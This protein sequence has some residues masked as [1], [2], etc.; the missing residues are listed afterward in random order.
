MLPPLPETIGFSY[1]SPAI[2]A[3]NNLD[4]TAS[5]DL[6]GNPRIVDVPSVPDSGNGTPPIVDMGAY[7]FQIL[8]Y[9][10]TVIRAG[11][12]SGSVS[13]I[14]AGIDCGTTCTAQYLPGTLV[15]LTATPFIS[16]TF[17]GWSGAVVSMANTITLTADMA[18]DVTATFTLKTYSITPTAGAN[19][20]ITPDTPQTVN[21]GASQMFTITPNIGY[22]I[23]DVG[24]DGSSIGAV[25]A[26]T[27]TN[28]TANHT[29]TAAFGVNASTLYTLTVMLV[30]KGQGQVASLPPGLTCASGSC[31]AT[32]AAD[33]VVTLTATPLTA[34][35]FAGWSGAVVTTT[36]P[37]ILTM[38]AT[39]QVTATF[40]SYKIFLPLDHSQWVVKA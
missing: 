31:T 1:G 20:T 39:K 15:T 34:T 28:V 5:T 32:F 3:G 24:V 26:Y 35:V 17:T 23:T 9:G 37:L 10:L 30:G 8:T 2:D 22:H 33:A 36:N 38:D 13:S 7:E 25:S 6:D 16:S 40:H 14:P 27:F 21:Y 19:G 11:S 12:G 29:I 18:K 4:V